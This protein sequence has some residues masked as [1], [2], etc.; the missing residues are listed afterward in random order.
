MKKHKPRRAVSGRNL[1]SYFLY[2]MYIRCEFQYQCYHLSFLYFLFK[3]LF[4]WLHRVLAVVHRLFVA[5]CR[6]LSS[7]STWAS[8]HTGSPVMSRTGLVALLHVRCSRSRDGTHAPALEG[9]LLATGPPEK[10]LYF[11]LCWPIPSFNDPSL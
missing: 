1:V 8:E 6:L 5:A 7:C 11:H 2:T 10:S 9:R 3:Y 4:V